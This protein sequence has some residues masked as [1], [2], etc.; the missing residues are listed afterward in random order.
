[1]RPEHR[2][3]VARLTVV[4]FVAASGA[5][6]AAAANGFNFAMGICVEDRVEIQ[7][8]LQLP[9]PFVIREEE[10]FILEERSADRRAALTA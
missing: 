6:G 10:E 1:L 7:V 9:E 4:E 2:H 8:P 5:P 3:P